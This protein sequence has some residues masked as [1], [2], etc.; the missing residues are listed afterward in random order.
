MTSSNKTIKRKRSKSRIEPLTKKNVK[1]LLKETVN[2]KRT[3]KS[4]KSC[5]EREVKYQKTHKGWFGSDKCNT[6]C[7]RCSLCSTYPH[8]IE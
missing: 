3:C 7:I 4:C 1:K 8:G 2:C 5:H 6:T